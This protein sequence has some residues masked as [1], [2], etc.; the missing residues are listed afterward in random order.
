MKFRV[1]PT[2]EC[3]FSL[4]AGLHQGGPF[5]QTLNHLNNRSRRVTLWDKVEVVEERKSCKECA[6]TTITTP[7]TTTYNNKKR[8]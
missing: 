8:P 4:S 7:S 5:E 3:F 2:V 6:T 1:L